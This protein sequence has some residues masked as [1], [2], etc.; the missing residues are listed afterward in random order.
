MIRWMNTEIRCIHRA[1]A[2][3]CGLMISSGCEEA[4]SVAASDPEEPVQAAEA[5][6]DDDDVDFRDGGCGANYMQGDG[7]KTCKYKGKVSSYNRTTKGECIKDGK[8]GYLDNRIKCTF[9]STDMCSWDITSSVTCVKPLPLTAYPGCPAGPAMDPIVS[10]GTFALEDGQ[11]HCDP[12]KPA[13][14]L[15]KLCGELY[16][17][18]TIDG[19]YGNMEHQKVCSDSTSPDVVKEFKCCVK[20]PAACGVDIDGEPMPCEYTGTDGDDG[21][22]DSGGCSTG[23]GS[24]SGDPGTTA[25]TSEPATTILEVEVPAL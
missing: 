13:A 24:S 23:D 20:K 9:T 10:T 5:A 14:D 6:Q 25:V 15:D 21:G 11:T 22:G 4:P 17:K 1:L 7:Q 2:L 12:P 19:V 3:A 16:Y 8:G 18:K